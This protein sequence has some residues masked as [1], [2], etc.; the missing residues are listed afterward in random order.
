[1]ENWS[2][3]VTTRVRFRQRCPSLSLR[4]QRVPGTEHWMLFT[5]HCTLRRLPGSTY[6]T[7][8]LSPPLAIIASITAVPVGASWSR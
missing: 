2:K 6:H 3:T 7:R 5:A 1:M 8:E 4:F